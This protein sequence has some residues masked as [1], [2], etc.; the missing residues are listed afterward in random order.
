MA[1]D[2]RTQLPAF[3]GEGPAETAERVRSDYRQTIAD[4][5]LAYIRDWNKWAHG[6][7]S[8]TREQAHGAPANLTDVYAS[9]D[10][11]ETEMM[12]FSNQGVEGYPKNKFASSAARDKGTTLSSSE[13]FTWLTE[14][15]NCPL[16]LVKQAADFLFLTG[17]NHIFFHGIPYS[18][19][20]APWPGWQFYA[21]VNFGPYG[22]LWHDL[23]E[24]NAYATRC[25]SVL[26]TGAPANDVLLYYNIFDVPDRTGTRATGLIT[27][28]N[29][30]MAASLTNTAVK[31]LKR[32]YAFDY[33]SDRFL[34]ETKFAA[35]QIM[36][37]GRPAKVSSSCRRA[38]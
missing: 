5:H 31:L 19:A 34:A 36:L 18:P 4:L 24:F 1:N 28:G 11:P 20:E 29:G 35:G 16:S 10:I 25:Q 8:L 27:T 30:P 26:Q 7:G 3:F 37:N 14:H 2:L 9:A 38:A 17:V 15:F 6:H 23:P 33:I 12:P 22:G 13:S 32:G 21:S